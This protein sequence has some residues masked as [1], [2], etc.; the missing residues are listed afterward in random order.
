M[1]GRRRAETTGTP[2]MTAWPTKSGTV[3]GDD[4]QHCHAQVGQD[5]DGLVRLER[6]GLQG[7]GE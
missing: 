1:L 6:H 3:D 7:R 4:R 5:L 2:S